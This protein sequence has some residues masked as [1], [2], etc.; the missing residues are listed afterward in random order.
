MLVNKDRHILPPVNIE[1]WGG[2]D[3]QQIKLLGKLSP[4][5]PGKKDPDSMIQLKIMFNNATVKYLKIVAKPLKV[6]PTLHTGTLPKVKTEGG[7]IFI[8]EIVVN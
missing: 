7:W 6:I 2:M 8:N 4:K 5:M 1:V 3:K